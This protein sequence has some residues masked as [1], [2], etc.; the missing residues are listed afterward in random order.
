MARLAPFFVI[1][2]AIS[3]IATGWWNLAIHKRVAQAKIDHMSRNVVESGLARWTRRIVT[4]IVLFFVCTA[5]ITGGV[6]FIQTLWNL[7][8]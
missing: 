6:I 7:F 5:L 3:A 2:G 8:N 4:G 1:L